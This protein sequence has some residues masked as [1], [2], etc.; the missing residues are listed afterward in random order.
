MKGKPY[1]DGI[2]YLFIRDPLTQQAALRTN[3]PEQRI[4]V[5]AVTSAEQATMMKA[6]GFKLLSTPIGPISLIPDSANA[7][8]P[9]SK[10]KVREAI[11]YAIDREG[12]SKARGF[13]IWK[14]AY[15]ISP[16]NMASYIPNFQGTRYNPPKAKQLLAEAGYPSGFKT[17][18]IV[19]PAMVDRDAMVAV[20]RNLGEVGIQVELEFP[21]MGGYT[22]YRFQGWKNA[23]MAHHTRALPNF[24]SSFQMY[25]HPGWK[26]FPSLKRPD[27]LVEA[28]EASTKTPE[29][30]AEKGQPISRSIAKETAVIPVYYVY[31]LYVLR[32]TVHDTGY[33]DWGGSTVYM[34]HNAWLSKK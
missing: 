23:F 29:M 32:P 17:K 34:P 30:G 28:I 8:S 11:S 18:I 25:F 1:L 15:Q 10:E 5:L 3:D 22:T 26:Q 2:D 14:A 16:D 31:E 19:M 20:Q 9:L 7:D 6:Q 33:G 4:D 12:I 24:N 13:G 21:D 27:G